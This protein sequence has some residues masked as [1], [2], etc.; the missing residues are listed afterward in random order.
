MRIAVFGAVVAVCALGCAPS[1]SRLVP[2]VSVAGAITHAARHGAGHT[3]RLAELTDFPWDTFVV[4]GPYT[5][6][7]S[8]ESV[9]GFPWP[10]YDKFEL[11]SS[12]SFSLLVFTKGQAIA[13]V[14]NL[15]RSPVEFAP[16]ALARRFTPAQAVFTLQATEGRLLLLPIT[17]SGA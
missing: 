17:G 5:D 2:N 9:L 4:F 16:V 1:E 8:A 12:E 15:A 13:R 6:R 14:E 3:I 7:A 10:D 11:A